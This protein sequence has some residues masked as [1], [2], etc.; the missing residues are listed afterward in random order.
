M[1][2]NYLIDTNEKK[3]FNFQSSID[4]SDSDSD[5]DGDSDRNMENSIDRNSNNLEETPVNSRFNIFSPEI[6]KKRILIDTYQLNKNSNFNS[7][8]YEFNLYSSNQQETGNFNRTGGL[9]LYRNVIGFK[10]LDCVIENTTFTINN[11]NNEF[12]YFITGQLDDILISRLNN[13]INTNRLSRTIFEEPEIIN[14]L[15]EYVVILNNGIYDLNNINDCIPRD[16]AGIVIG[17]R[18]GRILPI[19]PSVITDETIPSPSLEDIN[20]FLKGKGKYYSLPQ[21][22]EYN[23]MVDINI[24]YDD[25]E[26]RIIVRSPLSLLPYWNK[27]QQTRGFAQ[28]LGFYNNIDQLQRI[29]FNGRD[30]NRIFGEDAIPENIRNPVKETINQINNSI[31]LDKYIIENIGEGANTTDNITICNRL[32]CSVSVIDH[33]NLNSNNIPFLSEPESKI[34]T[35]SNINIVSDID[36]YIKTFNDIVLDASLCDNATTFISSTFESNLEVRLVCINKIIDSSI[37]DSDDEDDD[38]EDDEDDEDP[39]QKLRTRYECHDYEYYELNRSE[40]IKFNRRYFD[41]PRVDYQD[42]NNL[43]NLIPSCYYMESP[44]SNIQG[45]E[46]I[47][48]LT[49]D[50]NRNER[51][52][53]LYDYKLNVCESSDQDSNYK[54]TYI[55]V[56]TNPPQTEITPLI[57]KNQYRCG[58]IADQIPHLDNS[59]I[60]LVIDQI[61]DIATIGNSI[62]LNI[63]ERISTKNT[64]FDDQINYIRAVEEYKQNYFYPIIL[65]KLSIK[66]YGDNGFILDNNGSDNSFE[67]ELTMMNSNNDM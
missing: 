24:Y 62:G 39:N 56:W 11:S 9:G 31:K 58:I 10:L 27:N 64:K 46:P 67:F 60:D 54:T 1:S 63:I 17:N 19:I 28:T 53:K 23:N 47:L 29:G 3:S 37:D 14:N 41:I 34:D 21:R 6:I 38:D 32:P 45:P 7:S 40:K 4:D 52:F 25:N 66:L 50:N 65:D 48:S 13:K 16:T 35:T 20:E 2:T 26:K 30:N 33:I 59:Y 51:I 43:I 36:K 12:S 57:S 49:G 22:V 61:P 18:T 8:D 55:L 42:P 15:T 5:S 44:S